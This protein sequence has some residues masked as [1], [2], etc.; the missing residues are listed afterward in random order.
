MI[1]SLFGEL[2]AE[3]VS[4]AEIHGGNPMQDVLFADA[5]KVMDQ[6]KTGVDSHH[7]N[8]P[9]IT[10][11]PPLLLRA[12]QAASLCGVSVRTWRMLDTAGRIPQPVRIGRTVLWRHDELR[13]WVAAGCPR[14]H[15]WE[16]M[17]S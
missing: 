10:N 12:P 9:T 3:I 16:T 8:L 14:R 17:Q 4:I 15:D 11:L 7:C 5:D 6:P 1:G 13:A 2:P